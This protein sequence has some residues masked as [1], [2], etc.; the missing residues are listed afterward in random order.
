MR[1]LP[2]GQLRAFVKYAKSYLKTDWQLSDYPIRLRHFG[3]LQGEFQ[4]QGK[5]IPCIAQIINWWSMTG[6]GETAE[7]ALAD[8]EKNFA[9]YRQAVGKVPRP[10]TRFVPAR[11]G[12][13]RQEE[14]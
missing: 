3:D 14:H 2:Y 11:V 4:G 13:Q 8:L 1:L 10:G 7:Q 12:A 5:L 9:E 6:C